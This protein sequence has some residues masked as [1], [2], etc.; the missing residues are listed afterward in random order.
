V[1]RA[2][3]ALLALQRALADAVV[4]RRIRGR[5]GGRLRYV[6]TEPAPLA[7]RVQELLVAVG[8]EHLAR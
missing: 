1:G 6:F 3:G 2:P 4:L 8:V 7:P 5:L